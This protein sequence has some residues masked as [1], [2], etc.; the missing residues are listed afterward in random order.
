MTRSQIN[1]IE[2]DESYVGSNVPEES[3]VDE[4]LDEIETE[5]TSVIREYSDMNFS[6]FSGSELIRDLQDLL[7]KLY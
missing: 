1:F 7:N 2:C 4:F 3:S 5:L 6:N